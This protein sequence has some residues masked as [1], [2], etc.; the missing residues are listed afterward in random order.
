MVWTFA[1]YDFQLLVL[2]SS[3]VQGGPYPWQPDVARSAAP[4]ATAY[5]VADAMLAL[6]G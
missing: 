2:S 1:Y 6:L 5:A 4:A 3:P